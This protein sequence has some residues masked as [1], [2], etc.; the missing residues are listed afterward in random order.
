MAELAA[1]RAEVEAAAVVDAARVVAAELEAL[2][3]SST[4]S[5]VS[6]DDD[7]H[8]ELNLA[9]EASQEQAAQ[10]AAVH[11]Q[12]RRGGS[13]DGRGRAGDG[14][15]DRR[16]CT[17]GWVD[18]DRSLYRRQSSPSLDRYHSHHGIQAIVR[19]VGPGG[20]WPT[21][22]KTNYVECATVMRVRLQV[23]HMWKAVRYGDVDYYEDRRALDTLITAFP[24]EMQ[25]SL[26]KK[27][28]AKEAWD[29][30]TVA[31]NGSDR[32]RKTTLQALCKEWENLAFKPGEDVDDFALCLNTLQQKMVQFS[33]DTYGEERAVEK[34]FRC[35][36]EKYKQIAQSIES[37]LDL[38]TMSIEE[39]IGRLKVVYGDEP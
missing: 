33:D 10:W 26:S 25:F 7:R 32:T 27:W 21:L 13:P 38:S 12:G 24:P 2:H 9:R 29:V 16:E 11:P 35:I 5:S 8:N 17:D 19:D 39:V 23:Q 36:P 15:P 18:R 31:R 4:G 3:A 22:T 6:T 37:L 20:G 14:S 30:I 1:A 34:L 28:T